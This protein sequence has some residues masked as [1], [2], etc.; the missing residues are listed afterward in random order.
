[1]VLWAP[2]GALKVWKVVYEFRDGCLS[3]F[4]TSC[5]IRSPLWLVW[6]SPFSIR[7]MYCGWMLPCDVNLFCVRFSLRWKALATLVC[8]SI[9]RQAWGEKWKEYFMGQM[10][11]F[12]GTFPNFLRGREFSVLWAICSL[13]WYSPRR[14]DLTDKR[15]FGTFC[16]LDMAFT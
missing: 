12:G 13:K 14:R 9:H 1:M 2:W 16:L 3:T 15:S 6:L 8:L 10:D 4:W 7:K 11:P 5:L